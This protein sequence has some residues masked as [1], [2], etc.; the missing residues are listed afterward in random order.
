MGKTPEERLL[1]GSSMLGTAKELIA[2][3]LPEDLSES[4]RRCRIYE[5]L[6]GE[7]F[8][9]EFR[10]RRELEGADCSRCPDHG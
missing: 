7:P 2:A 3:S 9:D 8:P 6:C 1:M 4:E 5:R 10:R